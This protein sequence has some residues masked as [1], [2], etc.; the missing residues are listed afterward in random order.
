MVT[1]LC[2]RLLFADSL[3]CIDIQSILKQ[4]AGAQQSTL[5]ARVLSFPIIPRVFKAGDWE[6]VR[7]WPELVTGLWAHHD[8]RKDFIEIHLDL[9]ELNLKKLLFVGQIIGVHIVHAQRE[10]LRIL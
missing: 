5:S 3:G 8:C 2:S 4:L 1:S 7:G 6:N 10:T 9:L